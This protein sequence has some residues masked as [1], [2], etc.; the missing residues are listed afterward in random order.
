[1]PAQHLNK[2]AELPVFTRALTRCE[3]P[4]PPGPTHEG[5]N[6]ADSSPQGYA[7]GGVLED[8]GRSLGI[9]KRWRKWWQTMGCDPDQLFPSAKKKCNLLFCHR[10]T[11][12]STQIWLK[13]LLDTHSFFSD[14]QIQRHI[15]LSQILAP[16]IGNSLE[17]RTNI[18]LAVSE[19]AAG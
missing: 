2:V 17:S 15:Q 9:Q 4:G 11:E 10:C 16:N 7:P 18:F 8:L 1:M 13:S 19:A 3:L 14:I 5:R 12:A 6:P